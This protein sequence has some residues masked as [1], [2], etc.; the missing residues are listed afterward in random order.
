MAITI[1]PTRK[2]HSSGWR[3]L[4]VTNGEIEADC[5]DVVHFEFEDGTSIRIDSLNG[6]INIFSSSYEFELR[7]MILSD[8]WV[9]VKRKRGK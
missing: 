6:E 7:P 2:K 1:K 8:A 4:F 9:D 5:P 3:R